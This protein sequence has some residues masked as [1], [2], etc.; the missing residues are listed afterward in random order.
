MYLV[1][2]PIGNLEDITQRALRTLREADLIAAEDTRVT[3]RLLAHYRID[4]PMLSYFEHN[5]ARRIPQ[6]LEALRQGQNVALVSN[7]G[8]P[9]IS[10]PGFPLIRAC[11]EAGI[12]VVPVPGPSAILAALAAS[13]LP[14]HEFWF[15]G[16]APRKASPRKRF[17]Q[18]SASSSATLIF[19]ESPFRIRALLEA[20]LEVY[21]DRRCALGRELTK[22]FE[23][24]IRGNLSEAIAWAA[25]NEPRGEFVL[26]IQGSS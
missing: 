10:D 4:R 13:G 5:E 20:S 14:V 3:G 1:S 21:G 7:A 2:T 18:E 15:R 12:G 26:L 9:G 16:F 19:Y 11:I 6:V 23:E 8:T 25:H 22:K 17:L 24:M